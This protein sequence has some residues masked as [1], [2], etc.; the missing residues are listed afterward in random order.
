VLTVLLSLSFAAT[1]D[2]VVDDYGATPQTIEIEAGDRIN[3]VF[4]GSTAQS[5]TSAAGQSDSWDSGLLHNVFWERQFDVGGTFTWYDQTFGSDD[6]NGQVS[7]VSG[8]IVVNGDTDGDGLSDSE[9]AALGTDPSLFDTDGDGLSDGEEAGNLGTDTDPLLFDTDADGLSDG[10]EVFVHLTDPLLDDTDHGGV[11]DGDEVGVTDPFDGTD[12]LPPS[13]LFM[14]VGPV[15]GT[16]T[17][18]VTNLKPGNRVGLWRSR[19]PG[20]HWDSVCDKPLR[21]RNAKLSITETV[22]AD[23]TA[24]FTFD[25][26]VVGTRYFQVRELESCKK[27]H[28][29]RITW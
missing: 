16:N 29:L 5:S 11:L 8:T 22:A 1:Y 7:G 25:T 13:Q 15:Q 4:L 27:S 20:L 9:E 24:T 19:Q 10:D 21:L 17:L 18:V 23:G 2:I 26:T 12:D 6:G 3:F 14:T 28:P